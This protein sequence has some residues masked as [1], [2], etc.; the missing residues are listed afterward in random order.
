MSFRDRM[1]NRFEAR[2]RTVAANISPEAQRRIDECASIMRRQESGKITGEQ[3][4]LEFDMLL[5]RDDPTRLI[6]YSDSTGMTAPWN[7]DVMLF[8]K[9]G[10]TP[11]NLIPSNTGIFAR[12]EFRGWFVTHP[13]G[14][15]PDCMPEV[16]A[17]FIP[18][19]KGWIGGGP[20]S[21]PVEPAP[22]EVKTNTD[23]GQ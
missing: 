7:A 14:A 11:E 6:Y 8:P 1:R 16:I 13:S 9:P 22:S 19:N 12:G 17:H 4:S 15:E 18:G 23:R 2:R 21:P 5:M 10:S 3:G 20:K